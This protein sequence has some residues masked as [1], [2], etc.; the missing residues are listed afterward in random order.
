MKCK[1]NKNMVACVFWGISIAAYMFQCYWRSLARLIVP[2]VIVFLLLEVRNIR[3]SLGKGWIKVYALFFLYL[4]LS[5]IVSCFKGTTISSALRFYLILLTIPIALCI[6]EPRFEKEW[7]VIKLI[8][9]VKAFTILLTWIDVFIKQDY[10]NY[11]VWAREMGVGDI[12]IVHG[13]PRIQLL[14]TSIFVML[15]V[16]EYLKKGKITLYGFLMVL[17]A[18]AAGNAAYILGLVVF[19]GMYYFPT[20]INWIAKRNG[21]LLFAIPIALVIII[22]FS[23]YA[24]STMKLKANY[25]N[26]IRI[27]QIQV[28]T[29]TN[30][31]VGDGLGHSV[32]GGGRLRK[33][34]GD[35]YFELQTLYI[36]NQIGAVG[37][38]LFYILTITPYMGKKN[39]RKL[40]VYL[41]YLI[42]TFF[43]P[44][45]FD[46]THIISVLLITNCI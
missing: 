44:Y 3:P 42:Y 29:D 12:Y 1:I 43:N 25:S 19:A 40:L 11:R 27:E 13:I 10:W 21:R 26:A 4:S 30:P 20:F 28:L 36:Y 33:Y 31:I 18:L 14:G 35:T 45:C 16:C 6:K 39:R 34:D 7:I 32:H 41:T 46:S 8:S 5:F 17:S 2:A 24:F 9:L 15:F 37:L 23:Y 38:G 22:L